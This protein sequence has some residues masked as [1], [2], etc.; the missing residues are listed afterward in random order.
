MTNTSKIVVIGAWRARDTDI[1]IIIVFD[2][3]I[4][5]IARLATAVIPGR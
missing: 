4:I 2:S 5:E 1:E 3:H